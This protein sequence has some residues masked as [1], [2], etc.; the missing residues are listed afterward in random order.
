MQLAFSLYL[1]V[2]SMCEVAC[3]AEGLVTYN[4]NTWVL[5]HHTDPVYC[6]GCHAV[7]P[8]LMA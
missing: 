4:C 3:L 7:T 6:D 2:D 1:V 8:G 5:R